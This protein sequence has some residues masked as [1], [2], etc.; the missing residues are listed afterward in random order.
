MIPRKQPSGAQNR[1]RKKKEQ[2]EANEL[3]GS[4][5]KFL[6]RN[7][8]VSDFEKNDNF[9]IPPSTSN[10]S[11]DISN[12]F[13]KNDFESIFGFLFNGSKLVSLFDDELKNII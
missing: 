6:V 9:N 10:D 7:Q 11:V 12:Y 3:R 2:Q 13:E 5:N 1:K 8:N 4:L